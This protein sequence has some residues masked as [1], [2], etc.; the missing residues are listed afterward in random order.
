MMIIHMNTH[1]ASFCFAFGVVIVVLD[2][3]LVEQRRPYNDYVFGAG[4][5]AI[6][7]GAVLVQG[8]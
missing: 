7:L 2:R 1:I 4:V 5:G 8:W 3:L 6:L